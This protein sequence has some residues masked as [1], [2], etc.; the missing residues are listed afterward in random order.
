MGRKRRFDDDGVIYGLQMACYHA[1]YDYQQGLKSFLDAAGVSR[2]KLQVWQK[3]LAPDVHTHYLNPYDIELIIEVTKDTHILQAVGHLASV[4]WVDAEKAAAVPGDLDL[5]KVFSSLGSK[6]SAIS[7][8][9][10]Q[11]LSDGEVDDIEFARLEAFQQDLDRAQ[12]ELTKMVEHY[13]RA[14]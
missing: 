2:E 14:K 11:A 3:K 7:D 10:A 9:V 12:A 5:L 1:V 8:H 13:R 6:S 4:V